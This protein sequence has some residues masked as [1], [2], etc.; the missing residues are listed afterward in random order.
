[1]ISTSIYATRYVV[2]AV[3][4]G[5]FNGDPFAFNRTDPYNPTH[6]N[7]TGTYI[8]DNRTDSEIQLLP[9]SVQFIY[10]D[11]T[12]GQKHLDQF[13]AV[14]TGTCENALLGSGVKNPWTMLLAEVMDLKSNSTPGGLIPGTW[15]SVVGAWAY[16]PADDLWTCPLG[17]AGQDCETLGIG[18]YSGTSRWLGWNTTTS[19]VSCRARQLPGMCE[20]RSSTTLLGVVIACNLVKL[21]CI[22]ATSFHKDFCPLATLGDAVVSFLEHEDLVTAD[23]GAR[24]MHLYRGSGDPSLWVVKGRRWWRAV[25]ISRWSLCVGTSGT[26]WIVALALLIGAASSSTATIG[27]LWDIS[28]AAYSI[29]GF[30]TSTAGS[31]VQ[32]NILLANLP[33]LLISLIYI[34][35]SNIL[36]CMLQAAEW[37]KFAVAHQPLRVSKPRGQQKSTPWLQISYIYSIPFMAAMAL[38]HWAVSRSIYLVQIVVRDEKGQYMPF[39]RDGSG[40]FSACGF[41]LSALVLALALGG[42]M[43]LV[44]LALGRR[45]LSPGAP[46]VGRCSLAI[47]AACHADPAEGELWLKP[48]MYGIIPALSGGR[49]RNRPRVGLSSRDVDKTATDLAYV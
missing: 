4:E 39:L 27:S 21:A 22:T 43:V 41:N 49:P 42:C 7:E 23:H 1:M 38:L 19:V 26:F 15:G 17:L 31:S 32:A 12:W 46:V 28:H 24:S 14:D 16:N 29:S 13:D 30:I 5:F 36:T 34:S 6:T 44:L 9:G 35:Y 25:G 8:H 48:L 33:Q 45:R 2:A 10:D 20:L 47:S 3:D 11:L 37:S 18:I 40:S